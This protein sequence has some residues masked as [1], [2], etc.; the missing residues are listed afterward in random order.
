MRV[1]IYY[2]NSIPQTIKSIF[3]IFLKSL[4]FTYSIMVSNIVLIGYMGCGKSTV[5][6]QLSI[7]LNKSFLD[8]DDYIEA[9]EKKTIAEIFS[10]RG[11]IYFRK[12]EREYLLQCLEASNNTII[13]LGGGTPC[14][15]DNMEIVLKDEN[16]TS[17]Y[18]RTGI[19]TLVDR[20]FDERGK[21]PLIAHT[22]SKE[23][24]SEFIG[25]HLFERSHYYSLSDN[26]ILT[27]GRTV[28]ELVHLF[29]ASL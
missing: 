25:K 7:R 10:E 27:D 26:T 6:K 11:E 22:N 9:K 2:L 12:K 24:L 21:R 15:G 17:F 8:L 1:Q 14:F 23:E 29:E 13:S 4:H 18:L 20:L 3:L 19:P 5:G 28:E 16:S